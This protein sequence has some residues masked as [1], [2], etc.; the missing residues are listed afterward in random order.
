MNYT[1]NLFHIDNLKEVAGLPFHEVLL[2]PAFCSRTGQ[3]VLD[4]MTTCLKE[5]HHNGK[6]VV[7]NC[8][9]LYHDPEVEMF[10]KQL[11]LFSENLDAIRFTDPG[12]GEMLKEKFP[13]LRLQFS[14]ETNNFNSTG[15]QKWCEIFG[16]S[17]ERI[18]FSNQLPL[19]E[20]SNIVQK[21]V[22]PLEVQGVKRLCLF[23]SKRKLLQNIQTKKTAHDLEM[24]CASEDRPNQVSTVMENEHGT[25]MFQDRDLFILDYADELEAAGVKFIR[26]CLYEKEQYALLKS[27]LVEENWQN[28]LKEKWPR[29]TTNGFLHANNSHKQFKLLSNEFIQA[30]KQN[31]YGEVLE[32]TKKSHLV[33]QLQKELQLPAEI[34]FITPEGREVPFHLDYVQPLSGNRQIT[35]PQPG[36]YAMPWVKYVVPASIMV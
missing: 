34:R 9:L 29:K 16:V 23:Y 32:S 26:M 11:A 22:V 13:E 5:L 7:L 3:I 31:Q 15:I 2:Q 17:L 12:L 19:E 20:L 21:A 28:A 33:I 36:V 30:E 14:M 6:K 18:I 25:F 24:V 1:I 10:S 27:I 4:D 8:D 35:A